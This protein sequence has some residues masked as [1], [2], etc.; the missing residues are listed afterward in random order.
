M[1]ISLSMDPY[2]YA[3]TITMRHTSSPLETAKALSYKCPFVPNRLYTFRRLDYKS[4]KFLC[5]YT[6]IPFF[7]FGRSFLFRHSST[8]CSLGL[9][10][11]CKAT[12]KILKTILFQPHFFTFIHTTYQELIIFRYMYLFK[13]FL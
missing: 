1:Y 2:K 13:G 12:W 10:S 8:V 7:Y 3:L 9:S 11:F 4:K 5:N 6:R